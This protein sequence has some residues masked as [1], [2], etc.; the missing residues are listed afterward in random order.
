LKGGVQGALGLGNL[1]LS[2]H[3]VIMAAFT[4]NFSDCN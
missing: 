1:I 3:Y 2:L 4:F